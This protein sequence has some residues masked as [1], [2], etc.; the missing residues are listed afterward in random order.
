[1]LVLVP[2]S[3][4]KTAPV[5]GRPLDLGS[6]S[7]PS[8]TATRQT[9]LEALVS[10]CVSDP[11]SAAQALGLGPTQT[12]AVAYNAGLLSAPTARADRIFSGVLYA[13]ADLARLDA[14]A[15]R[16][17]S[18]TVAIASALFGLVRP[19]DRIPAYRLSGDASL[20]GLGPVAAVWRRPLATIVPD[21]V[22]D[23]LLVDMRSQTY[24]NLYRPAAAV[25]ARTATLRVLHD[26]AGTRRVVSHLNKAT[27]GRIVHELFAAGVTAPTAIELAVALR[28]LGWTVELDGGRLDVVVGAL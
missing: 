17:A 16:R 9:V 6:L 27:K 12:D 21:L 1:V 28:D 25:A 26:S 23:G 10:A 24:V 5:R 8:L 20:P 14:P 19:N 7:M 3:E 22:G 13:A 4:G 11:V 18:R 15:R 2:P